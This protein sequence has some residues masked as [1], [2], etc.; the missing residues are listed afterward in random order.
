MNS[1]EKIIVAPLGQ[2]LKDARLVA[3][4]SVEEVAEQLNLGVFTV[5][6]LENSLDELLRSNKYPVIYLRGYLVNYGKLVGLD[7]LNQFIEYQ[8]L[9]LPDCKKEMVLR[10]PVS[11]SVDKSKKSKP[12]FSILVSILVIVMVVYFMMHRSSQKSS[13]NNNDLQQVEKSDPVI[14][15]KEAVQLLVTPELADAIGN[16]NKI[17]ISDPVIEHVK[18]ENF[19]PETLQLTEKEEPVIEKVTVIEFLTLRFFADCWTEVTDVTGKRVAFNL[20]KGGDILKV[21]GVAPFKLILGDPSVV[22][23]QY[24]DTIIK[25]EFVAGHSARFSVPEK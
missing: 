17:D 18:K 22:E 1:Q 19:V 5:R 16:A 20:Y 11:L 25:R 15:K 9:S 8:Q 6:E 4:L 2:A 3:S 14:L 7:K 13:V 12:W 10:H 24:Q 23:I 21:S